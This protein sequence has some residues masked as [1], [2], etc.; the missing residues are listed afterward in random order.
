MER[1][2]GRKEKAC[3]VLRGPILCRKMKRLYKSFGSGEKERV[4]VRK[5]VERCRRLRDIENDLVRLKG[6]ERI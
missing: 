1:I 3:R 4:E 2:W 6:L 5:G